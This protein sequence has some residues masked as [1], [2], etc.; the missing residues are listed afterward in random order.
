MRPAEVL[1]PPSEWMPSYT[2]DDQAKV[3]LVL[4]WLNEPRARAR[5]WSRSGLARAAG[6]NKGTCHQVLSGKYPSSPSQFLRALV[7]IVQRETLRER[8]GLS[9]LA[10]V[11][12]SVYR[13]VLAACHR[14]HLYRNFAVV[15][16]YVGTGK[17]VAV[18]RYAEE[19]ANAYLVEAT[20]G[21]TASVL[22]SELVELTGATVHRANRYSAG[23]KDERFRGV[24]RA[25]R[26]TDSLLIVDEAE[27]V[28]AQTL[29]YVRRIRDLAR[30]GVVLSG[31]EDLKP[32]L[33]D[34]RGRFGQISSRVGFWPPIVKGI[35]EEDAQTIVRALLGER[36]DL[37][38]EV[39]DAFWQVCAGSARVLAEDVVTG[40]RDYG[41]KKG[42]PLTPELVFKVG[43][44][45][46][47]YR[48]PPARRA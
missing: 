29:E 39:L 47:G 2:A 9:E 3:G 41:L 15:S 48:K 44:D 42:K 45:L 43:Q 33:R 30:I 36:E 24:V 17:T 7:E 37:T 21:M 27:T 22:L 16:A 25:L 26:G 6:M 28:T 8:D 12:T 19:H 32:M 23:S 4:E 46:L 11:E 10:F 13:L 38:E 18:K 5:G 35:T 20:P 40:V 34:P 14:A 31:A 1:T